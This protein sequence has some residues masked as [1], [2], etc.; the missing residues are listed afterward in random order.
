MN[1]DFMQKLFDKYGIL[2]SKRELVLVK[3]AHA[4]GMSEAYTEYRNAIGEESPDMVE[5]LLK[6]IT[7]KI[8][9]AKN[10]LTGL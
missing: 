9:K 7:N 5:D 6:T 2:L 10:E 1:S 4:A 8:Y 3:A